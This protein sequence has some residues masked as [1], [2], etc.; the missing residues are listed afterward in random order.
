MLTIDDIDLKRM[1]ALSNSLPVTQD[2]LTELKEAIEEISDDYLNSIAAHDGI[3]IRGKNPDEAGLYISVLCCADIFGWKQW[4]PFL[5]IGMP[6]R[7]FFAQDGDDC[8]LI[9]THLGK[10]GVYVMAISSADWQYAKYV[11]PSIRAMLCN[12]E[13]W[14]NGELE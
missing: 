8:F 13:G 5:D 12:G 11:T 4:Y 14:A 2:N 10:T 6:S 7:F 3:D 1:N 9:G